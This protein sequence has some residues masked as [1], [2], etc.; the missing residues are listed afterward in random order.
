MRNIPQG[1]ERTSFWCPSLAGALLLFSFVLSY[2][3]LNAQSY[4]DCNRDEYAF[5]NGERVEYKVRYNW[6]MVWI[7]AGR[8]NFTV[9]D[10]SYRGEPAFLFRGAGKTLPAY[11]WVYKV[12]DEY[13]SIADRGNLRPYRFKRNVKEGSTEYY[14][15]Y[16][17]DHDRQKV[18]MA[19]SNEKKKE[20]LDTMDLMSCA[21]DVVTAMYHSRSIDFRSKTPG[22][23]IPLTLLL[24]EELYHTTIT[25]GGRDTITIPGRDE[26]FHCIKFMPS[27]IPG[28]IFSEDS[29]MAVWVTDDRNKVPVLVEAEILVGTVKAVLSGFDR[30]KYPTRGILER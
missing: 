28:S 20:K 3:L 29:E 2:T 7:T 6:N 9:T 24:D 25:Y 14:E 8:V 18:F 1:L 22:D 17:F 30:L 21:F 12:R 26:R 23:T 27:L 10:T 16:L 11:D 15:D 19:G 5:G 13:L 4:S